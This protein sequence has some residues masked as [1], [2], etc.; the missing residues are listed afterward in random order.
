M[1][2]QTSASAGSELPG[3]QPPSD[4]HRRGICLSRWSRSIIDF[5]HGSL[6]YPAPKQLIPDLDFDPYGIGGPPPHAHG[7]ADVEG[8][9]SQPRQRP[10]WTPLGGE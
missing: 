4:R 3:P 7:A 2:Q 8:T 6:P 5:F 1:P 10:H 9:E